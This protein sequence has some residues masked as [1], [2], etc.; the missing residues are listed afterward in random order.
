MRILH[1]AQKDGSDRQCLPRPGTF[2]CQE[3]GRAYEREVRDLSGRRPVQD[4]HHISRETRELQ[5]KY[6]EMI[7]IVQVVY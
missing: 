5:A 4:N 6:G 1:I 2:H 3:P 7:S